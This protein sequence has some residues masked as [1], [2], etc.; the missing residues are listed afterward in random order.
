[1]ENQRNQVI[2]CAMLGINVAAVLGVACFIYY[3]TNR[4]CEFCQA[5]EFIEVVDAIP[6]RPAALLIIVVGLL[7]LMICS[8]VLREVLYPGRARLVKVTLIT[9]VLTCAALMYLL[10]FNFNVLVLWVFASLMPYIRKQRD[11]Y[12]FMAFAIIGFVGTDFQLLSINMRLYSIRDY[13]SYYVGNVQQLFLGVYNLCIAADIVVFIIL[14]LE[15]IQMQR[16]TIEEV[17]ILYQRLQ[18]TNGELQ[19]ANEKLQSY[20]LM[21]EKMGETKERNR[22]AREI[23]DTLGHTLTGISA[24]IDACLTI[25]ESSPERTKQQLEI[26][27]NVAREGIQEIRRS[28]NELRPDALNRFGLEEAIQKM[29]AD[30]TSM[31]KVY[32]HYENFGVKL[33]FDEDEENAIYRVIQESMTNA[34]RHGQ[35]TEIWIAVKKDNGDLFLEVKDNGI[36][37]EEMK[38]GFGTRH[39]VERIEMLNGEVFFD[40]SGGFCVRARIPIRWG[41]EY[42]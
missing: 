28:V 40:G 36:G 27:S 23:H 24:G 1:M 33:K 6:A 30:M 26:I 16:G 20:A 7:S 3:T 32:V 15:V 11:Q 14:C 41:E 39:I 19:E 35:A 25:V 18:Q 37:C 17:S 38:K 5:R 29:I 9:D 21:Q 13:I 34:L 2:K 8:F 31:S 22:L 12:M 10:D 4:I 42:D